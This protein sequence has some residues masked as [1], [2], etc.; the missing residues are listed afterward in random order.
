M[1]WIDMNA[2]AHDVLIFTSSIL[3]ATAPAFQPSS[4]RSLCVAEPSW[5]LVQSLP[6]DGTLAFVSSLPVLLNS[7]ICELVD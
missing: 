2:L 1:G 4:P 6:Y 5:K 7:R 3:E